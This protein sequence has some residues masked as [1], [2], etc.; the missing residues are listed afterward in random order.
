M[1]RFPI[2]FFLMPAFVTSTRSLIL[3]AM[4]P[5]AILA[6]GVYGYRQLAAEP[7]TVTLPPTPSAAIRTQVAQLKKGNYP[8]RLISLGILQAHNQVSLAPQVTGKMVKLGRMFEAGAFF[9]KGDIL[10]E[11]EAA[12]YL[13]AIK[14]AEARLKGCEANVE[15][16]AKNLNRSNIVSVQN[17]ITAAEMDELN[18]ILQLRMSERHSAKTELDKAARDLERT[19]ILTPFDGRVL[20]RSVSIGDTVSNNSTLGVLIATDYAEVR[21]PLVA[22]DLK[23]VKLPEH[24]DDSYQ[25][26]SQL[27][28]PLPALPQRCLIARCKVI[29][30]SFPWPF[31][32]ASI[33][34]L[35]H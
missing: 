17:A 4:L 24:L 32:W 16:A 15:L 34:S 31:L 8:V 2:T 29:D 5:V 10:L 28:L 27:R 26:G 11:I 12:D 14:I 35:P 1:I 22:N 33:Y 13:T 19:K 3:R 18:A 20:A 30:S 23:F 6:G 21:L 25:Y 7:P 9:A